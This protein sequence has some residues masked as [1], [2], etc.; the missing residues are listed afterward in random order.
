[1][2]ERARTIPTGEWF[3]QNA[4]D[5]FS[6]GARIGSQLRGGE[7]LLLNGQLGAGKTIFAK[8]VASALDIDPTEVSSPTF[9]L[10][11]RYNGRLTLYHL[12]LYRLAPGE[13]AAHAVGLDE[14]LEETESVVLIEWGERLQNYPLPDSS[15]WIVTIEQVGDESR[16]IA[17]KA[18]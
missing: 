9:T 16:R 18:V 14:L 8:G 12:D 7:I 17:I 11:N 1:M 2:S 15:C 6:L 4:D 3:S 13:A 10:V 5:T